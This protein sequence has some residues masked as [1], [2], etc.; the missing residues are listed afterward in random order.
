MRVEL[1]IALVLL[2]SPLG[3]FAKRA[4]PHPVTP[5]VDTNI[6]YSAQGSGQKQFVVATET[7][8]GKELWK[9]EIFHVNYKP[10]L[11]RDV[12]DVFIK[13]LKRA[14]GGLLIKDERSRCYFLDLSTRK[15]RKRL[16][17]F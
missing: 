16:S 14:R 13:E 5:I 2:V 6:R 3:L 4:Q 9:A 17:C 7:S 1:A 10:D 15:V 12:Q 11:E 8:T